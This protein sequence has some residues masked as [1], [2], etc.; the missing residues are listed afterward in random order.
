M[1]RKFGHKHFGFLYTE[2]LEVT[3]DGFKFKGNTYFWKDIKEISR[4]DT[5]LYTLLYYQYGYPRS[6]IYLID[7][8]KFYIQGRILQEEGK[9]SE[10]KFWSTTKAYNELMSLMES[11]RQKDV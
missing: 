10:F 2:L 5:F 6:V 8:K 4:F 11:K 9:K 3:E 1:R 7:G